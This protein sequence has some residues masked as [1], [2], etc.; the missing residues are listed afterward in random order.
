MVS[1]T[2]V[3]GTGGRLALVR[4][5]WWAI[6][7]SPLWGAEWGDKVGRRRGARLCRFLRWGSTLQF[8]RKRVKLSR[9]RFRRDTSRRC[10]WARAEWE[11]FI[12]PAIR[13]REILLR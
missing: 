13:K 10:K 6:T 12:R 9:L 2:S 5:Y 4:R 11:L 8:S 3:Y 7:A 1:P